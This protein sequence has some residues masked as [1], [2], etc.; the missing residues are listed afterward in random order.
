MKNQYEVRGEV[1]A[2][3]LRRRNGETLETL[4]STGKLERAKA[5]PGS[6]YASYDKKLGG[7]Y[8]RGN[9]DGKTLRLHRYLVNPAPGVVVD[10]KNHDTLDNTDDNL[11]EATHTENMQN[12]QGAPRQSKTGVRGVYPLEGKYAAHIQRN[13][14]RNYLGL[15]DTVEQASD[16]LKEWRKNNIPKGVKIN[17]HEEPHR[18]S[19]N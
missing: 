10:H 18:G 17:G 19:K 8:V 1:T 2:I 5:Y 4:I 11:V 9:L 16:A 7:Y 6:W 12:R 13:G 14:K 3:F 15:F